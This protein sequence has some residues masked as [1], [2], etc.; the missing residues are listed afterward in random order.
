MRAALHLVQ[1]LTSTHRASHAPRHAPPP[2]RLLR[3][4]E[5]G[6]PE[7]AVFLPAYGLLYR[8]WMRQC[9]KL[10]WVCLG[11]LSLAAG[12]YDLY[13][14]IPGAKQALAAIYHL[15]GVPEA[16]RGA[17][18]G[19]APACIVGAETQRTRALLPLGVC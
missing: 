6:L 3:L 14:N 7:W 12:F 9:A 17:A 11:V 5:S 18:V 15:S 13:R 2:Q 16:R 8:R 4:V 1:A 10:L 19:H